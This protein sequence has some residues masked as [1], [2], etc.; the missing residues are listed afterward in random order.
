MVPHLGLPVRGPFRRRT[1]GKSKFPP[2]PGGISAVTCEPFL[3]CG[4]AVLSQ[5]GDGEPTTTKTRQ[6][7]VCRLI[8]LFEK[9]ACLE[10][11]ALHPSLAEPYQQRPMTPA[12][13]LGAK[14]C[15]LSA[16]CMPMATI[17]QDMRLEDTHLVSTS[18]RLLSV[19]TL[20]T[21]MRPAAI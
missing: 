21:L 9:R 7:R 11:M 10:G 20:L 12:S 6:A 17:A 8:R 2:G 13:A 19:R 16:K 5:N 14:A 3:C 1:L 15:R 4:L 18:A